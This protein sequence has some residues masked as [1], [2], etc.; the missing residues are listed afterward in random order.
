MLGDGL[1]YNHNQRMLIKMQPGGAAANQPEWFPWGGAYCDARALRLRC[2]DA[3]AAV[4]PVQ[5]ILDA[6]LAIEGDG[7]RKLTKEED[8]ASDFLRELLQ[9]FMAM[10]AGNQ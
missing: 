4:P 9:P 2:A 10:Q 3:A 1:T 8:A 7:K 5:R 6:V